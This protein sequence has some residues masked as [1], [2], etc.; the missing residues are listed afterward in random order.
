MKKHQKNIR[1][2]IS[3]LLLSV[4]ILS[5]AYIFLEANHHCTEKNCPICH[6]IEVCGHILSSVGSAPLS[7]SIYCFSAISFFIV[8]FAYFYYAVSVTLISL[9]VK[10]SD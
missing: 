4:L 8:I 3:V 6:E 10:L 7:A 9:K 5:A 2:F 1:I